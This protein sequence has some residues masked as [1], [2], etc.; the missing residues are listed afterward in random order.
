VTSG[1]GARFTARYDSDCNDC[2]GMILEGDDAGW[3]DDEVVC[4]SCYD[5]ATDD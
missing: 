5:A 1:R 4:S 2:G 3:V